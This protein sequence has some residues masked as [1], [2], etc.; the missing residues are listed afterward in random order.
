VLEIEGLQVHYGRIPAVRDVTVNVRQ[1]EIVC[2]VGPNGAGKS[3]MLRTIAGG[4][5]PTKGDIRLNGGSIRGRAPEDIAR[6]GLS[7]VPE[8]RHVFTQ[9][10]VEENI[11]IGAAMRRDKQDEIEQDFEGILGNFGFLRER[12]STPAGKLSGGEQQQLVIGRA[13]MTGAKLVLLDE[14]SLGLAPMVV[15]TVFEIINRLRANGITFLVVEQSTHR[16][17]E[18]ADRIY[19]LRNGEVRLHGPSSELGDDQLEQAYFGFDSSAK[20][21]AHF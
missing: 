11:R 20:A 2:I 12:L 15:D 10:T 21:T 7:L 14:P 3:T 5:R 9:L 17:L 8:G 4:L 19:V 18:H 13:L 16:A 1:S 6:L